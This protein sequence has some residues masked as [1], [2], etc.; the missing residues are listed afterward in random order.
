MGTT[1]AG[2]PLND[3]KFGMLYGNH[4]RDLNKKENWPKSF[5]KDYLWNQLG[6]HA[7]L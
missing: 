2:N 4:I 7:I 6:A 3:E 5:P 1:A